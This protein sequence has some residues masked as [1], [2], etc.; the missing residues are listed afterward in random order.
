MR[1][2]EDT[3]QLS[4]NPCL[5]TKDERQQT[6]RTLFRDLIGGF[7][8]Q[9]A[10]ARHPSDDSIV[11]ISSESTDCDFVWKFAIQNNYVTWRTIRDIQGIKVRITID[12]WMCD[13]MTDVYC[14]IWQYS[15]SSL[16]LD[17]EPTDL[18]TTRLN[19]QGSPRCTWWCPSGERRGY[20]LLKIPPGGVLDNHM[21][22]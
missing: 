10:S 14:I 8:K 22:R 17:H 16:S 18:R 5:V 21:L 15:L 3:L 11:H 6:W 13:I 1:E 2:R 9:P 7:L 20:F 4:H 19:R 12:R